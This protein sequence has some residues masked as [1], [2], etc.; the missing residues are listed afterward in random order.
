MGK[1]LRVWGSAERWGGITRN[2]DGYEKMAR[3]TKKKEGR[4][5]NSQGY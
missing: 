3:N 5:K 1:V 4:V 2:T